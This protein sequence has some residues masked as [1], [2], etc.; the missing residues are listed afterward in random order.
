MTGA[1]SV[2]VDIKPVRPCPSPP[3][4]HFATNAY[5]VT[6]SAPLI[7]PANLV[8]EYSYLVPAPSFIYRADNVDGPWVS[9]GG[10][11]SQPFT[12]QTTSSGLGY[13][14]AGYPANAVSAWRCESDLLPIAV[15]VLIVGVMVAG[16]PLAIARRRRQEAASSMRPMTSRPA[17]RAIVV[18]AAAAV[19]LVAAWM[20]APGFYDGIAPQQP[21]NWVCPPP[22]AGADSGQK[23]SSGHLVIKVIDGS[24]DPNSVFTDDGQ[25]I[26]GFLPG[27]FDATGKT[28]ITVDITPVSPCPKPAD[29]HFATN[30]YR[31]TADAKLVMKANLVMR[32]SNLVPAPSSIYEAQDPN[33]PWWSIGG[34]E[35]QIYTI[36][37][38][39]SQLG[40]VGAGY[41][42]NAQRPESVRH[43][44]D[45]SDRGCGPHR[46]RAD[47][48]DSTGDDAAAIRWGGRRRG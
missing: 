40:Y 34:N 13:F 25:I 4:L 27:A 44:P 48:R 26:V 5:L 47:R 46:R 43:Q 10:N 42:G 37:A 17:G 38:T 2:S 15:A 9:I 3:A 8:M 36:Q 14:A 6:A 16:I 24:S 31:I 23:A 39:I 19:Y 35:G 30:V 7:K 29:V 12:I 11:E 21:Y 22:V 32:Y 1:T 45:T 28:Q 33:G 20:V 41:P 18:A